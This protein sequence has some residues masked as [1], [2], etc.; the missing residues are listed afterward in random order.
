MRRGRRDKTVGSCPAA[1]S[2]LSVIKS[3]ES[4]RAELRS[5]A[6]NSGNVV[7]YTKEHGY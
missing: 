2:G 4:E 5:L 1:G 7:N 3:F 6:V